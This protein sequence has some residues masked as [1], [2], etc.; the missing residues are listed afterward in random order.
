MKQNLNS[1]RYSKQ[2]EENDDSLQKGIILPSDLLVK[3][4][5]YS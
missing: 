3:R 4:P 2:G 1:E 5:T